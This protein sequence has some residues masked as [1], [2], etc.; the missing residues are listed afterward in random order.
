MHVNVYVSECM[1]VCEL[2]LQLA[3]SLVVGREKGLQ[4]KLV[5]ETSSLLE[6]GCGGQGGATRMVSLCPERT[7]LLLR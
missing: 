4:K 7:V 3:G 5:C 1:C 6:R 2:L